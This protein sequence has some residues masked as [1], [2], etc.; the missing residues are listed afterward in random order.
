MQTGMQAVTSRFNMM[1]AFVFVILA[2]AMVSLVAPMSRAIC[3][4]G[5]LVVMLALVL[6]E[7]KNKEEVVS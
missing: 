2:A 7:T 6:L 5:V 4:V 3:D 1:W